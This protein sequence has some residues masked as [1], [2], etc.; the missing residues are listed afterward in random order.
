MRLVVAWLVNV[1]ALLVAGLLVTSVGA[2]DPFA[3]VAWA[4]MFGLVCASLRHAPR[5]GRVPVAWVTSAALLF[6]VCIVM[7]GLMTLIAPPVHAPNVTTIARAATVMWLANLPLRLL[8][9]RRPP[10]SPPRG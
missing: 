2:S 4:A 9:R 6:A 5:L 1:V 10:G 3:Y 8:F 7:V